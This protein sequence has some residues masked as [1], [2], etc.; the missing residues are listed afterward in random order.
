MSKA[1]ILPSIECSQ[2]CEV[3]H[4]MNSGDTFIALTILLDE[5]FWT[6]ILGNPQIEMVIKNVHKF[7]T[8]FGKF[9]DRKS[10]ILVIIRYVT[11]RNK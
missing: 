1:L 5:I 3:T 7:Q 4:L 10:I 6:G 2:Q 11:A 8:V 9:K